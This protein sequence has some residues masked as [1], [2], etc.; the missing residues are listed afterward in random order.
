MSKTH[1]V[2]IEL[3]TE[4]MLLFKAAANAECTSVRG[5]VTLLARTRAEEISKRIIKDPDS[6]LGREY[7]TLQQKPRVKIPTPISPPDWWEQVIE[8]LR[9]AGLRVL[10]EKAMKMRQEKNLLTEWESFREQA[11]EKII[12]IP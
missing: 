4:Q 12:A 3:T 9:D 8:D 2:K 10:C 6:A 11:H 1:A 7:Q 5:M